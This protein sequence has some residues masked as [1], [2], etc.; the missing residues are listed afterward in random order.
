MLWLL[1]KNGLVFGEKG[2]VSINFISHITEA[3][4]LLA[5]AEL[6]EDI[7]ISEFGCTFK[8]N[9]FNLIKSILSRKCVSLAVYG[10]TTVLSLAD[11]EE[12]IQVRYVTKDI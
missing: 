9:P 10:R 2:N 5:L 6:V 12:L 11:G 4:D 3:D 1:V 7:S 8:Q